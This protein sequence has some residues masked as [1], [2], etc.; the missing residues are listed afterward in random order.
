M[1]AITTG[2]DLGSLALRN[3]R[4]LRPNF[5][6]NPRSAATPTHLHHGDSQ[7]PREK[8]LFPGAESYPDHE[9]SRDRGRSRPE[10]PAR[11]SGGSLLE[12]SEKD[13]H[14]PA[15][16]PATSSLDNTLT[17]SA[18]FRQ[19]ASGPVKPAV[20]GT[21]PESASTLSLKQALRRM[22]LIPPSLV[23][24]DEKQQASGSA[25]SSANNFSGAK[26]AVRPC[27]D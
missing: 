16:V 4:P 20:Q 18:G 15:A 19:D 8:A 2:Q 21:I 5:S 26:Y 10:A 11:T 24:P 22:S 27:L 17:N 1:D 6:L 12:V 7:Q 14:S 3:R 25:D 13:G 9:H 23:V